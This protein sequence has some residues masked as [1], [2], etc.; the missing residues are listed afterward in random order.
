MNIVAKFDLEAIQRRMD[1]NPIVPPEVVREAKAAIE[2]EEILS[3]PE[4]ILAEL[5]ELFE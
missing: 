5:R 1:D 3:E 2:V 4:R